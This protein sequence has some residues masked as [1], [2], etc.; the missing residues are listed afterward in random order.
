[1]ENRLQDEVLERVRESTSWGGKCKSVCDNGQMEWDSWLDI[2]FVNLPGVLNPMTLKSISLFAFCCLGFLGCFEENHY[3]PIDRLP[4]SITI[5]NSFS[6]TS[7]MDPFY[8]IK[9]RYSNEN[10]I[11]KICTEFRLSKCQS[12]SMAIA[13][14]FDKRHNLS[15]FPLIN[16]SRHYCYCS[17]NEDGTMKEDSNFERVDLVLW[18]DEATNEFILQEAGL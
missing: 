5:L 4:S 6:D 1:M 13:S 8:L 7:G 15:W 3:T 16:P 9:G 18:I 10:E 17:I 2:R 14:I 11:K 12:P